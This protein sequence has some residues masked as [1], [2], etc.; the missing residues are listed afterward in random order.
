MTRLILFFLKLYKRLL[1]PLLGARC[2]YHPS[3][4][5]YARIAVARHGALRGGL[6]AGWRLLRCNPA[7]AGGIDPVPLTFTFR[8]PPNA[9][10]S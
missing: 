1:S 6:L 2:R 3:C 4:G 8:R 7:S 5:D 9:D 10:D